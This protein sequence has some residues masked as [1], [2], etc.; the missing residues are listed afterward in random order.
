[1]IRYDKLSG[2]STSAGLLVAALLLTGCLSPLAK[3]SAALADAT[4]PV[5]DQAKN[6][7]LSAQA[8]HDLR[9]N[10]DAASQFDSSQPVYN[11]RNI[12][13][14]LSEKDI[15]IRLTVLAALQTYVHSVVAIAYGTNS[16]ELEAASKSVGS[17]L[18]SLGNL[19]APSIEEVLNLPTTSASTTETAVTTTSGN[20]VSTTSS[21]SI[22]AADPITPE[23]RN[24]IST[25]TNADPGSISK[26]LLTSE[27]LSKDCIRKGSR[28]MPP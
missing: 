3:R 28:K 26:P 16:P 22:T 1:M 5:V 9:T 18:S 14:L 20:T 27:N 2:F 10:Y 6:A 25:A 15:E 19:L 11:P 23:L 21:T 24:G 7:Y 8:L 17:S 13:P 12:Q 4:T